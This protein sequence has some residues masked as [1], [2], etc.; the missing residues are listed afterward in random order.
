MPYNKT[1][2]QKICRPAVF[3]PIKS[4]QAYLPALSA[5]WAAANRAIGTR[6]G[7]QLT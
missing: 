4:G 3:E 2:R 6:Y 5:A 7:L 1:G